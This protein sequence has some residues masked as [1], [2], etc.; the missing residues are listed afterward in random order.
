MRICITAA[1]KILKVDPLTLRELIKAKE[2]PIGR[3]YKKAG[4]SRYTFVLYEQEVRKFAKEMG[5]EQ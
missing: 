3:C 2:I 4:A 5:L 1:A